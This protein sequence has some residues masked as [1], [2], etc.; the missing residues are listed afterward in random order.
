MT[1]VKVSFAQSIISTLIDQIILGAGSTALVYL[2]DFILRKGPGLYFADI[3]SAIFIVYVVATLIYNSV[4]VA[5]KKATV[6]QKL[7]Q[8]MVVSK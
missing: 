1:E 8:L 4:M 7:Q 2:I 5:T 3:F 6:G